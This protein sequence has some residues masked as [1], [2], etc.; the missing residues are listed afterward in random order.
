[1]H[2]DAFVGYFCNKLQK[3]KVY[4]LR[5]QQPRKAGPRIKRRRIERNIS[6]NLIRK[7]KSKCHEGRGPVGIQIVSHLHVSETARRS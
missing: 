3:K 2:I 1:M 7:L 5:L 4:A 6:K